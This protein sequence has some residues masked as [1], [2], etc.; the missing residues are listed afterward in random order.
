MIGDVTEV[1][2]AQ[3]KTLPR[4]ME[5]RKKSTEGTI[6]SKVKVQKSYLSISKLPFISLENDKKD[7][8]IRIDERQK[9][10]D[11]EQQKH[12]GGKITYDCSHIT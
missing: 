6:E 9:N 7:E 11:D 5:A 3:G 8:T 1:M 12:P 2:T 4:V 10:E